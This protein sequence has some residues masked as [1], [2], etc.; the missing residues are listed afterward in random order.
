MCNQTLST[1]QVEI[2]LQSMKA[3]QSTL[4]T[5]Y[6]DRMN[7]ISSAKKQQRENPDYI[8]D[9]ERALNSRGYD[10]RIVFSD[11][12]FLS[13]DDSRLTD[14]IRFFEMQPYNTL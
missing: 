9:V 13:D 4:S 1:S 6:V 8:P 7:I 2:A 5:F 14:V 10:M 3:Q 12:D 11:N